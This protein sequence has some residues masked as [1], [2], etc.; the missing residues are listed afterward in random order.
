MHP[1]CLP[2][3]TNHLF[4]G[5]EWLD[6]KEEQEKDY[7]GLKLRQLAEALPEPEEETDEN[8]Q[9]DSTPVEPAWKAVEAVPT[10]VPAAAPAQDE[11]NKSVYISPAL[12]N[13]ALLAPTKLGKASKAAPD[14][15]SDTYFPALGTEPPKPVVLG[16]LNPAPRLGPQR[17]AWGAPA[18]SA[19]SG[20]SLG[21]R[22]NTLDTDDS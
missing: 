8:Q 4:Q 11:P 13:A 6:Y 2:L 14:L 20:V 3:N 17:S 10:P 12:R 1:N 16:K 7:S 21:N 22:Y 15:A 9:D 18:G 5:N 19:Q